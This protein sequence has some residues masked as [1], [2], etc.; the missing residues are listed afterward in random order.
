MKTFQL[1]IITPTNI[2]SFDSVSYLRIPSLDG[3]TGVQAKHA[4]SII[5]LGIGEIK[6]TID[7]S[8]KYFSTSGG[9]S[10]IKQEG[11]QLLL[12]TIEEISSIDKKRAEN[13]LERATQRLA[14][15]TKDI[16]RARQ[17]I[18]RAKNRLDILNKI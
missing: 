15:K 4:N 7:G 13:S 17:S 14:D 18:Q 6:I 12:E 11:V 8:E 3:L 9:F 16:S 1:D 5:A 10:D 2:Q